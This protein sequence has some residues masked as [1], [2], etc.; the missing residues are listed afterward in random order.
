M[1]NPNK[2]FAAAKARKRALLDVIRADDAGHAIRIVQEQRALG[3]IAKASRYRIGSRNDRLYA[4][5]VHV[6]LKP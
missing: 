2:A 6:Y 4:H 3:R 1:S 5:H